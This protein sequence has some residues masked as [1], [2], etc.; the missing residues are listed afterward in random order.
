MPKQVDLTPREYRVDKRRPASHIPTPRRK[1]HWLL[2][3]G[4]VLNFLAPGAGFWAGTVIVFGRNVAPHAA[5]WEILVWAFAPAAIGGLI[6][7]ITDLVQ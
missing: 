5:P 1:R 4:F 3:N 2:E 6:V 7:V